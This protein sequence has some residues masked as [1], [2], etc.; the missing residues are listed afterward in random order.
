MTDSFCRERKLADSF[1]PC[2]QPLFQILYRREVDVDRRLRRHDNIDRN[3]RCFT[4]LNR[5][6]LCRGN[7]Y[8]D[9]TEEQ[10]IWQRETL[11]RAYTRAGAS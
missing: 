11:D 1:I 4:S 8:A 3:D 9:K 7:G 2:V 5:R 6:S 10:A